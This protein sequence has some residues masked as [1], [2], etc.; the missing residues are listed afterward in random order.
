MWDHTQYL[1]RGLS[2]FC[3]PANTP[4]PTCT[5]RDHKNNGKCSSGCNLGETE[6]WTINMGCKSGHQSA[7]CTV[8]AKS[9]E[10]YSECRW[11]G[12]APKC[13]G[14]SHS[15]PLETCSKE[16]PNTAIETVAGFEGTAAC[17]SGK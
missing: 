1:G 15:H 4:Q 13:W 8:N 9:V 16:Y 14:D 5:W 11:E 12:Q 7:C 17:K 3:C 10:A 6:V 2:S